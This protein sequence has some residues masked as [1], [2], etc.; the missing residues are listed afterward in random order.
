MVYFQ[1]LAFN[2]N[3]KLSFKQIIANHS[4]A[5]ADS[6]Q[7]KTAPNSLEQHR[8][9]TH[10]TRYRNVRIRFVMALIPNGQI[11]NIQTMKRNYNDKNYINRS[12][13]L[14]LDENF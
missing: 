14:S 1:Q 9:H 10:N 13:T 8:V 5:S 4:R 6:K 11:K 2:V 3:G 12:H 7:T